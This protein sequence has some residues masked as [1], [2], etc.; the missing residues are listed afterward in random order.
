[1]AA[2]DV[3]KAIGGNLCVNF[4]PQNADIKTTGKLTTVCWPEAGGP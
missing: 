2:P 1:M 4:N 3:S